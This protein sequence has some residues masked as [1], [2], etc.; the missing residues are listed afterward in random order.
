MY[1]QAWSYA[2]TSIYMLFTALGRS[3]LG[4]TVPEVFS[5]KRACFGLWLIERGMLHLDRDSCGLLLIERG[6]LH[7]ERGSCGL[8]FIKRGMLHLKNVCFG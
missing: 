4:E 7:L 8:W 6:M 2:H 3:V 1:F 5:T